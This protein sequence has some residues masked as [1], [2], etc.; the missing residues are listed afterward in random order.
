MALFFK[1]LSP[2]LAPFVQLQIGP[3]VTNAQLTFEETAGGL[4]TSFSSV[5][6]RK[7]NFLLFFLNAKLASSRQEGAEFVVV[8]LRLAVTVD[9]S[10]PK[11]GSGV[12]GIWLMRRPIGL[13]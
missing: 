10:F 8:S 3:F 6:E 4:A 9:R 12:E 7:T 5:S 2:A 13:N 1:K 11:L